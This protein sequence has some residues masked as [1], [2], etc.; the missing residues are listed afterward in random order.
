MLGIVY[1]TN[2]ITMDRCSVTYILH[3][4][5]GR[6][7]QQVYTPFGKN[8]ANKMQRIVATPFHSVYYIYH[9]SCLCIHA[10]IVNSS[11]CMVAGEC[12]DDCQCTS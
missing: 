12:L 6:K 7:H 3:S 10:S 8:L 11:A 9:S 4:Y 1:N 2:C 5:H